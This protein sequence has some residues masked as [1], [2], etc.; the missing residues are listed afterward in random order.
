MINFAAVTANSDIEIKEKIDRVE[1]ALFATKAALVE[2]VVPGGGIALISAVNKL[3][4]FISALII[5]AFLQRQS[6]GSLRFET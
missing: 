1:V 2:G 6:C 3:E 5:R 4:L